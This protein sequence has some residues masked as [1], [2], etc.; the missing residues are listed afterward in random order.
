MA[1]GK[2]KK[3]APETSFETAVE[4]ELQDAKRLTRLANEVKAS[5]PTIQPVIDGM[6]ELSS[7]TGSLNKYGKRNLIAHGRHAQGGQIDQQVF[8]SFL[9]QSVKSFKDCIEQNLKE[10]VSNPLTA[11]RI[12]AHLQHLVGKHGFS[13]MINPTAKTFLVKAVGNLDSASVKAACDVL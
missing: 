5:T 1:K 2:S 3:V 7:N 12:D 4:Q 9:T 8:A 10:A 13:I 11:S 6:V